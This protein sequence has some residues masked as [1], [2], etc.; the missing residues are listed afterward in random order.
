MN[1]DSP[2]RLV[3][4]NAER[5]PNADPAFEQDRRKLVTLAEPA[6]TPGPN[7]NASRPIE[8]CCPF[9]GSGEGFPCKVAGRQRYGFV[10]PARAEK[11]NGGQPT[12][13]TTLTKD[14]P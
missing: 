10:H 13:P 11:A 5:V 1:P 12:A 14:W 7:R 6:R 8:I 2:L 3:V 9:C 4:S